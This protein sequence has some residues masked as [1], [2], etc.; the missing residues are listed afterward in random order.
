MKIIKTPLVKVKKYITQKH[1]GNTM[2]IPFIKK[3]TANTN[4]IK[5]SKINNIGFYLATGKALFLMKY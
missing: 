5:L 3:K 1:F 4:V 2:N